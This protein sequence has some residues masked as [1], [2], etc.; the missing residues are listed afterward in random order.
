MMKNLAMEIS[1]ALHAPGF[2]FSPFLFLLQQ[3]QQ[4]SSRS[5]RWLIDAFDSFVRRQ[6]TLNTLM[7]FNLSHFEDF[8]TESSRCFDEFHPKTR[9]RSD[10]RFSGKATSLQ[11]FGNGDGLTFFL[12]LRSACSSFFLHRPSSTRRSSLL[13]I[14]S[15]FSSFLSYIFRF[16]FSRLWL[17]IHRFNSP[18]ANISGHE[19]FSSSSSSILYFFLSLFLSL[20]PP[21]RRA[22]NRRMMTVEGKAEKDI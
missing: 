16:S 21:R 9:R 5:R 18:F 12:F 8:P 3:H 10:E 7:H 22:K 14:F 19:I 1:N 4:N 15:F 20:L 17:S 6:P 2:F 13:S 11:R